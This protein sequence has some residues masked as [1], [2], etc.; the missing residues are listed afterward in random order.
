MEVPPEMQPPRSRAVFMAVFGI[1][2]L[3]VGRA[4]KRGREGPFLIL[5]SSSA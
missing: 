1:G 3:G 2:G 5:F 4:E